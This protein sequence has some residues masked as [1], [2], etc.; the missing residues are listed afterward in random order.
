VVA[1]RLDRLGVDHLPFTLKVLLDNLLRYED[2]QLV[3][4]E[5]VEA[6]LR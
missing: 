1:A 4:A 6:V 3:T 2:G 5:Q